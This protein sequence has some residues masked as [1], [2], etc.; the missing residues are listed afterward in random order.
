MSL[1]Q[2]VILVADGEHDVLIA[3]RDVAALEVVSLPADIALV[4]RP[5]RTEAGWRVRLRAAARRL[6]YRLA[7]MRVDGVEA[8]VPTRIF[9]AKELFLCVTTTSNFHWGHSPQR[10]AEMEAR[11]GGWWDLQGDP[12]VFNGHAYPSSRFMAAGAHQFGLP[13]TWLIDGNV[14]ET[15]HA[16]IA[17]W[18]FAHGDDVGI[19]PSSYFFHNA[20][21]YN[22]DRS[23]TEAQAVWETTRGRIQRALAQ[24]GWRM[25]PVVGGVDQWVGSLGSNWIAAGA[26]AGLR[27]FWGICHDHETCDGSVYHEGAPWEPYRIN[28]ANFRYP[29]P[30]GNGP[31]AFPWTARD[32]CNSF[33]EYP[34]A[35]CVY[36]TDPD[37]ITGGGILANQPDYWDRLVRA[38]LDSL[39]HSDFS[40]LVIHNEDHDAH[41][42]ASEAYLEQ[43]YARLPAEVA[44]ATLEEVR[45]WLELRFPPGTHPSQLLEIPDPLT[46]HDAVAAKRISYPRATW[47]PPAHWKSVAGHNPTVLC[48][49]GADARWVV[50]EAERVPRQY[51][52]YTAP[53]RFQETG[54]SP[55]TPVPQLT[56]WRETGDGRVRF[57]ANREFRRLPIVWWDRPDVR[58]H[59]QTQRARIVFADVVRGHNEII[60]P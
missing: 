1:L 22:T 56:D 48:Y 28:P 33:L 58:G 38:H 47:S 59:R 6:D 49:Y 30:A 13:V 54:A 39:P 26:A 10:V 11:G 2:K 50:V 9:G 45:Q 27:A 4:A 42:L 35:S 24:S 5:E 60:L 41:R 16:E 15:A 3:D 53:A 20:V 31:W 34:G 55:K 12:V 25:W 17:G 44:P 23:A 7:V 32:L 14:A 37:D 21:N 40:C 18:H 43:F 29:D 52:D 57:V 36:S 51:I 46:C 19:L 8:R